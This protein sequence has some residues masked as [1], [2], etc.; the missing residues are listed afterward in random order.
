MALLSKIWTSKGSGAAST[1][2]SK[3]RVDDETINRRGI[4]ATVDADADADGTCRTCLDLSDTSCRGEG[5]AAG[6]QLKSCLSARSLGLSP[7]SDDDAEP[8]ADRRRS[9]SV[10]FNTVEFREYPIVLGDNPSTSSGPPIG[11]GW[12]FDTTTLVSD[13]DSYEAR[14]DGDGGEERRGTL[15]R[16]KS[17][18]RIPREVRDYMLVRS[19]YSRQEIRSATQEAKKERDRRFASLR[20]QRFDPIVHGLDDARRGLTSLVCGRREG[21]SS[22]REPPASV[23]DTSYHHTTRRWSRRSESSD[24]NTTLAD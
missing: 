24:P 8:S 12:E 18:L 9:S 13:V 2:A 10:R 16:S 7:S 3:K 6:R 14:R 11:I 22:A 20:R 23:L 4:G 19:G 5:T 15:R 1:A 21:R 17:E